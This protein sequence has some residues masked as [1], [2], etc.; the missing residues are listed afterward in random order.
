MTSSKP[1]LLGNTWTGSIGSGGGRLANGVAQFFEAVVYSQLHRIQ[2]E[3]GKPARGAREGEIMI[4]F[5]LT[6]QQRKLLAALRARD[7]HAVRLHLADLGFIDMV[8]SDKAA[9]EQ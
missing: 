9:A 5:D 8:Q 4:S 1:S 2:C 6:P 3:M 7:Q